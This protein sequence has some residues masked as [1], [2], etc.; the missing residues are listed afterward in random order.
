MS[1]CGSFRIDQLNEW[2]VS[3][4]QDRSCLSADAGAVCEVVCEAQQERRG[5]CPSDLRGSDQADD[6]V[7]PDE[8]TRAA[9]SAPTLERDASPSRKIRI[10]ALVARSGFD[11]LIAV[12]TDE[13]DSR[14]SASARICL[15]MITA[16]LA[17]V[18][19]QVLFF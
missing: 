10:V 8:N 2:Q 19:E 3:P 15:T 5:R 4:P 6:A 18:K 17:V 7:R 12:M 13:D 11:Q 16:Q 14:V 9:V 1:A